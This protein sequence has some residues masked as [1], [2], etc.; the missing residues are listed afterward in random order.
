MWILLQYSFFWTVTL[1]TCSD[2]S[3]CLSFYIDLWLFAGHPLQVYWN[4]RNCQY[5][6]ILYQ[7]KR[8]FHMFNFLFESKTKQFLHVKIPKYFFFCTH[9]GKCLAPLLPALQILQMS[10]KL[11]LLAMWM[12]KV[13]IKLIVQI[14]IFIEI[15]VKLATIATNFGVWQ[16]HIHEQIFKLLFSS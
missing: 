7:L 10:R 13:F 14:L 8:Q 1:I 9:W 2:S 12:K 6:S 5:L 15:S 11:L 16:V 4:I 3:I